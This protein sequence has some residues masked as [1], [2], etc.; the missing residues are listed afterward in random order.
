MLNVLN[1]SK[2]KLH[3]RCFD[4]NLQKFLRTNT[5][6]NVTGHIFLDS[7]INGRFM[8]KQLNDL[9]SKWK[10]LIKRM[11]SLLAAREICYILVVDE[12]LPKVVK[13]DQDSSP[14][15]LLFPRNTFI[16]LVT[17]FILI[18]MYFYYILTY[19]AM[20]RSKL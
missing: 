6:E 17:H 11:P 3:H 8:L 4:N 5:L 20:S 18:S 10:E 15:S 19:G 12:D 7:C 9:N 2:N 16:L 13:I 1:F 14:D